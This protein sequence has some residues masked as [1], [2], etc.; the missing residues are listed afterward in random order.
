VSL[1]AYY[2]NDDVAQK[3]EGPDERTEKPITGASAP[4]TARRAAANTKRAIV[5]KMMLQLMLVASSDSADDGSSR[6]RFV[7]VFV[8]DVAVV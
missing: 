4:K 2:L 8:D 7:S 5:L 3:N 1:P 6:F